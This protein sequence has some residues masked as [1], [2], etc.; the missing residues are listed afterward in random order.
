[1][2]WNDLREYVERLDQLGFLRRV[3]GADW[4]LELGA[5]ADN[6]ILGL[7]GGIISGI[8]GWALFSVVAFYVGTKMLPGAT[9][10]STPR[11]TRSSS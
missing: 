10:K 4:N 9:S 7:I 6:G 5:I 2:L 3:E 11:S 1:M 8:A